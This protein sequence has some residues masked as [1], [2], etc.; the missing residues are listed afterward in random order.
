MYK[1]PL[2]AFLLHNNIYMQCSGSLFPSCSLLHTNAIDMNTEEKTGIKSLGSLGSTLL[3]V[4]T[5]FISSICLM[6]LILFN[7]NYYTGSI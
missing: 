4:F 5:T 2:Y 7:I 6:K 1:T 3:Q